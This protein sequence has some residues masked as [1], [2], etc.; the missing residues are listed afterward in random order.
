[1]H[2]LGTRTIERATEVDISLVIGM[3]R[4]NERTLKSNTETALCVIGSALFWTWAF[5]WALNPAMMPDSPTTRVP[6]MQIA[7]TSS[8]IAYLIMALG[9]FAAFTNDRPTLTKSGTVWFTALVVIS[10]AAESCLLYFPLGELATTACGVAIGVVNGAGLV[11]LSIVWSARYVVAGRR[12]GFV[13]ALS[14]AAAFAC[15]LALGLLPSSLGSAFVPLLPGISMAIWY[16]DAAIRQCR[17]SEVWP[18]H[19]GDVAQPLAGESVDGEGNPSI[20]PWRAMASLSIVMLLASFFNTLKETTSSGISETIAFALPCALCLVYSFALKRSIPHSNLGIAYTLLIPVATMA[21]LAI[22]LFGGTISSVVSG[23]LTGSAYLL[24]VTIW[25]Q[26]AKTTIDESLSPLVSFG[27]GGTVVTA[28]QLV[29][30]SAGSLAR[31]AELTTH[32]DASLFAAAG[33]MALILSTVVLFYRQDISATQNDSAPEDRDVRDEA[34]AQANID[35][36]IKAFSERYG[37]SNRESEILG[38]FVRGRNIPYVAEKLYVTPGTVKTHSNHIYQKT[39][40]ANRQQLFD[41]FED[42]E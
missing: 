22:M 2:A 42:A 10:T 35:F 19:E 18:S 16:A 30:V 36:K 27:V 9:L 1:M 13:I 6:L 7:Y 38:Y 23:A 32:W 4:R 26:L 33:I 28:L 34:L 17:T 15:N 24:H 39:G 3:L 25:V 31:F 20:L 8:M 5:D 21:L 12:A 40:V 11:Y 29:G 14:F 37:L 41:L